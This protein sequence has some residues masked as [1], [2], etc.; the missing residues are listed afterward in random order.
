MKLKVF[1][2]V[3]VPEGIPQKSSLLINI[4]DSSVLVEATNPYFIDYH[5]MS[6]KMS[7]DI[8]KTLE[9]GNITLI[10]NQQYI[11][12]NGGLDGG[13]E[14]QLFNLGFI[15]SDTGSERVV[16]DLQYSMTSAGRNISAKLIAGDQIYGGSGSIASG[17]DLVLKVQIETPFNDYQ[18]MA[19]SLTIKRS[20]SFRATF[21]K[22]EHKFEINGSLNNYPEG[23]LSF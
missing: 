19:A 8:K 2:F 9:T 12:I 4:D 11:E 7:Y 16:A 17:S 14:S 23:K 21:T 5:N 15:Y 3:Y 1:E 13:E 22:N 20:N 18:Q 6:L 10:K